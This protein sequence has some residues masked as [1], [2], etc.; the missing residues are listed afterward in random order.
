MAR[1]PEIRGSE[2][3]PSLADF[4]TRS[5]RMRAFVDIVRRVV[6][7]D[8][9]LL[10]TGP[11]GV[12]KERLARAIHAEGPR[13]DQPFVA[14]NCGALPESLLE[15]ELFG[16]EKG[17]FTGADRAR[18]GQ[19]ELASGGII[20]LDEIGE[21]PTH[22]QVKLLTVLQRHEVTPIGGQQPIAVDVRVIAA[23]NRDLHAEVERGKF[24]E[25]L[26]YRLNV[27]P[28]EIPA[29]STRP[30]DIVDLAGRFIAH[31]REAMPESRVES[32]SDDAVGALMR[33]AWPGNIRELINVIERAMVLGR[34]RAIGLA[35]L[36]PAIRGTPD[37]T[38][39]DVP[40]TVDTSRD[41]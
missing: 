24:R 40:T 27:L 22:L 12:G 3:S 37:T 20:F 25:D 41:Y 31:F 28:L 13:S 17:A 34:T 16:H 30:D 1:G 10:I 38:T 9:S 19:F 29:L 32:I 39:D 26:F 23:T 35:D 2:A 11:T 5:P 33:Y 18:K 36:P 8:T 15:S 6:D 7:V 4:L 14:V 21:M